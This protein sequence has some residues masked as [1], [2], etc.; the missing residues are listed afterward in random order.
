MLCKEFLLAFLEEEEYKR[1][2]FFWESGEDGVL[3]ERQFG[4]RVSVQEKEGGLLYERNDGEFG[5]D[6]FF[7]FLIQVSIFRAVC[8]T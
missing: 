4:R 2:F 6:F 7:L 5:V 3:Y 8:F 1:F